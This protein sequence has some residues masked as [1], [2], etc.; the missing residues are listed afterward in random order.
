[1]GGYKTDFLWGGDSS[2]G[3]EGNE[4][5]RE[6]DWYRPP[7]Q[8]KVKSNVGG[9]VI[10]GKYGKK[11]IPNLASRDLKYGRLKEE[12]RTKGARSVP[13]SSTARREQ[14]GGK[15]VVIQSRNAPERKE[16]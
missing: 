16:A 3:G 15:R 6:M 10:P 9:R 5:K 11:E 1:M 7:H 4:T 14:E 8:K 13:L 12:N 2:G